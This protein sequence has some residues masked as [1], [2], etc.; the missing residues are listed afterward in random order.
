MDVRL[1]KLKRG[2]CGLNIGLCPGPY[3]G[4]PMPGNAIHVAEDTFRFFEPAIKL[5]LSGRSLNHWGIT[6]LTHQEWLTILG[7]WR[8]LRILLMKAQIPL[9]LPVL[10]LVPTHAR[11]IFMRDFARNC[12]G[13]AKMI[14]LLE[15]WL[16]DELESNNELFIA[17]I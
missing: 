17:G 7:A 9:D 11:R 16:R 3:R 13:L 5:N 2:H 1:K 8:D 14:G 4:D 15:E 12:R 6:K 10:R